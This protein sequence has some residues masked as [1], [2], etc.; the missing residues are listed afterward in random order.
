MDRPIEKFGYSIKEAAESIGVCER[1][2]R[3]MVSQGTIRAKHIGRRLVIA[4]SEIERVLNG[5]D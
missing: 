5:P 4:R 3:Q 1:L 2:I